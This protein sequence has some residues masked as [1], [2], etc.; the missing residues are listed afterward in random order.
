MT[1]LESFIVDARRAALVKGS[2]SLT[3]GLL[4]PM[5]QMMMARAAGNLSGAFVGA[6]VL[7]CAL[8]ALLFVS[9]LRLPASVDQAAAECRDDGGSL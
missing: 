4:A 3:G 8:H 9:A 5:A 6:F 1:G 2:F 7:L